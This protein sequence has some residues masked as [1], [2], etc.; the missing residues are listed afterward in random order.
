MQNRPA[1]ICEPNRFCEALASA[2]GVTSLGEVPAVTHEPPVRLPRV[3]IDDPY[4]LTTAEKQAIADGFASRFAAVGL[5]CDPTASAWGTRHPLIAL[6]EQLSDVLPCIQRMPYA[7]QAEDGT[8][9]LKDDG[10]PVVLARSNRAIP[11]HQD[12]LSSGASTKLVGLWA[13][14]AAALNP[15]TFT[16]NLLRVIIDLRNAD[17][18]AFGVLFAADAVTIR[19]KVDGFTIVSS[20]LLLDHNGVPRVFFR[21]P[22]PEYDVIPAAPR[23]AKLA[24]DYLISYSRIDAPG[25]AH[26]ELA[27]PGSGLLFDNHVNVHGRTSFQNGRH[28]NE[29]RLL[30]VAAWT[31]SMDEVVGPVGRAV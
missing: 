4:A 17:E 16:Q 7:V 22:G 3:A 25:S 29:A 31:D 24:V 30:A 23:A 8:G 9:K 19:R 21:T 15:R 14:S 28:A 6:G 18:E 5:Q 10:D 2:L 27:P 26:I 20:V 1:T 13:D 12:G 11:A